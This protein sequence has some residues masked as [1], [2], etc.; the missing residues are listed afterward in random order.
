VAE[1]LAKEVLTAPGQEVEVLNT[2]EV[3]AAGARLPAAR[4]AATGCCGG[5][6]AGLQQ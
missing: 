5:G 1:T 6:R 2:N 3:R 4:A